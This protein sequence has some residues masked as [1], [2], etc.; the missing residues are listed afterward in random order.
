VILVFA[1]IIGVVVSSAAW[2]VLELVHGIQAGVYEELPGD[3][4]FDSAP[5]G[6]RC[7]GWRSL[8]CSP[9]SRSHDFPTP[10]ATFRRTG[11]AAVPDR[12]RRTTT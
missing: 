9:R 7:R 2:A 3:L 1:A 11:W 12:P 6:G 5:C 10:A 4:G 8:G